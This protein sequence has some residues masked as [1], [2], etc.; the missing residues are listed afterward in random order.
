MDATFVAWAPLNKASDE[1]H[2]VPYRGRTDEHLFR[3]GGF[4]TFLLSQK[5]ESANVL[6]RA[7]TALLPDV[8]HLHHYINVGIELL[9]ALRRLDPAPRV[10]VTLHE[11]R[12]MCHHRGR[13]LVGAHGNCLV[14]RWHCRIAT[15][16]C[17]VANSSALV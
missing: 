2:V 9:G 7:I 6:A 12:T 1:P 5:S 15:G 14:W 17:R 8:V 13:P 11:F 10:F 4:D 16:R 3:A